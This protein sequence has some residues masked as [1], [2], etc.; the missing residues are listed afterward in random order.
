MIKMKK[1]KLH[2]QD[3]DATGLHTGHL[4]AKGTATI[5]STCQGK[6][7]IEAEYQPFTRKKKMRG[8]KKVFESAYGCPIYVNGEATYELENGTQVVVN[9]DNYDCSYEDWFNGVKSPILLKELTCPLIASN[10]NTDVVTQMGCTEF[11]F[12]GTPIGHWEC[13]KD[14]HKCW[15]RYEV[16]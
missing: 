15:E 16:K 10:Q 5:C 2:C 6:G 1:A 4:E 13:Y 11:A 9:F 3:C 8:I 12:M 14:K 7:F